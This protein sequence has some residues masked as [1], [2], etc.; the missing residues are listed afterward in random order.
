MWVLFQETRETFW[1]QQNRIKQRN[2]C[3]PS[4]EHR[5]GKC[6]FQNPGVLIGASL[7]GDLEIGP[8]ESPARGVRTTP[9][10]AVAS[11]S[12]SPCPWFHAP[13]CYPQILTLPNSPLL[14]RTLVDPAPLVYWLQSHEGLSNWCV[15]PMAI[16]LGQITLLPQQ[17]HIWVCPWSPCLGKKG[18]NILGD[19]LY[20]QDSRIPGEKKTKES[21]VHEGS[22]MP[23]S[24]RGSSIP[25]SSSTSAPRTQTT[26]TCQ[27]SKQSFLRVLV[28]L[29]RTWHSLSCLWK[30]QAD[31][32]V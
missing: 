9:P 10:P 28:V 21:Q 14:W 1:H 6:Y 27:K 12:V 5:C 26:S 17:T 31:I 20:F 29:Q 22:R 11:P 30:S 24:G 16:S 7:M 4:V 15:L 8:G 19:T 23:S 2:A 13:E 18:E 25:C 3:G 32:L